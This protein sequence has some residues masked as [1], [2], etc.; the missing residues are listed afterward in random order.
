MKLQ[1]V[2]WNDETPAGKTSSYKAHSKTVLAYNSESFEGFMID[3]SIPKFPAFNGFTVDTEIDSSEEI[4][5][6]HVF[7]LS[8]DRNMVGS[9]ITKAL[10]IK[11]YIYA[12]NLNNPD[13]IQNLM[14]SG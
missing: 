4:Y 8:L 11:P 13:A 2:A 9:M 12:T 14:N 10:P 5:G 3:H 6:Q 7:C 1:S